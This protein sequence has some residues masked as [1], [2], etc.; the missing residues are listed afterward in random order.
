ML[1][2]SSLPCASP[3]PEK[4]SAIEADDDLSLCSITARHGVNVP[5]KGYGCR[6]RWSLQDPVRNPG[7][8]PGPDYAQREDEV[9]LAAKGF[10][11]PGLR[12][13]DLHQLS[14][15]QGRLSAVPARPCARS[16]RRGRRRRGG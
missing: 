1:P 4:G 11:L 2:A 5:E 13:G 9:L 8:L 15:A 7:L 16:A 6:R 10:G 3:V 12:A 14:T